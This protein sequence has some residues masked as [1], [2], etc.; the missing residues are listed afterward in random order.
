MAHKINL[1]KKM[2]FGYKLEDL[3][4][5]FI[6]MKKRVKRIAETHKTN[7]LFDKDFNSYL[8]KQKEQVKAGLFLMYH[9]Y[10]SGAALFGVGMGVI[11][12]VKALF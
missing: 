5:C 6:G 7:P 11:Y 8:S 1:N 2:N 3:T 12:G 4:P 9:I 10:T